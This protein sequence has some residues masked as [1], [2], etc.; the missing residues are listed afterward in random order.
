MG[1]NLY[2]FC[3]GGKLDQ[4]AGGTLYAS[5]KK[6]LGG[7]DMVGK[8]GGK[9]VDQQEGKRSTPCCQLR[10]SVGTN[11]R[12]KGTRQRR[13]QKQSLQYQEVRHSGKKNGKGGGG[14]EKQLRGVG[15]LPGLGS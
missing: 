1:V 8:R 15:L 6:R 7:L 9:L 14:G 10:R 2:F 5:R 12:R 11:L 4:F 3:G 13:K